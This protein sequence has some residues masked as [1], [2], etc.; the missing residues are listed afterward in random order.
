MADARLAATSAEVA[1]NALPARNIAAVSLDALTTQATTPSRQIASLSFDA[2][3][4]TATIP[5]RRLA[6]LS[7]EILAP[8]KFTFIGWGTPVKSQSW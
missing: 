4:T 7:V 6:S 8:R 5:E 1:V 3:T 2:L